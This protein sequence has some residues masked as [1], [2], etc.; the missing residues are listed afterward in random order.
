METNSKEK[1]GFL[2]LHVVICQIISVR[3]FKS[4]RDCTLLEMGALLA[5]DY[6][7]SFSMFI[8]FIISTAWSSKFS[9]RA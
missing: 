1:I 9:L 4:F 8:S 5:A 7:F 3:V 6:Y 2:S